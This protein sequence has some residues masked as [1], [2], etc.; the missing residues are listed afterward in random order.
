MI[1]RP[2]LARPSLLASSLHRALLT[3]V[4]PTAAAPER[5]EDVSATVASNGTGPTPA[6]EPSRLSTERRQIIAV[7]L[8]LPSADANAAEVTQSLSDQGVKALEQTIASNMSRMTGI[9]LLSRTGRGRYRV[10]DQTIAAIKQL[11][12]E[13]SGR[14]DL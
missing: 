14:L 13:E 4:L 6:I 5:T 11:E 1:V 9:G 10:P 3:S 8:K 7:M 12:R 2:M